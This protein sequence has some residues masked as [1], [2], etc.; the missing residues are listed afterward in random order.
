MRLSWDSSLSYEELV[1]FRRFSA[2]GP[3]ES[4]SAGFIDSVLEMKYP[5][6]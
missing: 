5:L 4:E 3:E 2:V 1:G 6:C